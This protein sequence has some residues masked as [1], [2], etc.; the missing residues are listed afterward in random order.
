MPGRYLKNT[1][2]IASQSSIK[3]KG[4]SLL[5][6]TIVL[7][8]VGVLGVGSVLVYSEQATHAKWQESQQKLKVAKKAILKFA[9]VNKYMPCPDTTG[10]GLDSRTTAKGK[11]PAIPATPAT[12]AVPKTTTSPTIP[13]IPSTG[14]QPAIPNIDVST[15]SANSGSIPYDAIGL[16]KTD[17][18]DSWGNL[19]IYAVDQGVT[20]A[21]DMLDCPTATACF[22]NG[23]S[24]PTLPAGKVFPG[25]VLPAFDLT[26]E[27]LKGVLGAN[28]LRIC[29]DSACSTVESEGL[30]AVLVAL[31]ENG[32]VAA[33]LGASEAE[34]QDGDKDFVNDS[35]S[36]APYYDDLILGIAANEIKTRHEDESVEIVNN[37][38]SGTT[39][40]TGNDVGSLG[41]TK[42]GA[43]GTNLGTDTGILD[44]A[45]QSFSFGADRA[46]EKVVLTFDTHA[47]GAWDKAATAGEGV[48]DDRGSVSANGNKLREFDYDQLVDTWDGLE[49]VT[50]T[51]AINGQYSD[52]YNED[53][54][55][56]NQAV[57][58][59]E[60]VT[61]WQ[62]Y[63]NET[64]EYI[65]QLDENGD[66]AV[67]FQVETIATV[68][69]IDFT[70]I[71]L[72]YYDTPA[73][74][75]DF[76]SVSPIAGVP[77]SEGLE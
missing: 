59:G 36:E 60:D 41:D 17:V 25:S 52:I 56:D 23:D 66:I 44:E 64:H 32:K 11:I 72:V 5:E 50:F 34:N 22:F 8:I 1:T 74:I 33:G 68:E 7:G 45:S 15:C 39:T 46:N 10:T 35:Y 19:F 76:P 58:K 71:E 6:L 4:F 51:S 38:S 24:K 55:W 62:P 54:T 21:D 67:D 70:N 61:T 42:T 63:W 65:V 14:A 13:A 9:E 27:P 77:E 69:T 20:V 29:A 49:Q 37:S 16:S 28:N 3:S 43:V 57:T 47:L 26:T 48:F 75:P 2:H 73:D 31:N 12:P 53:G 18:Q 40:L 30:V